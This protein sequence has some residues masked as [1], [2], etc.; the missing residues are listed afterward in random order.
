M[1][2]D[3]HGTYKAAI[4]W[5]LMYF[6][7]LDLSFFYSSAF[8]WLVLYIDSFFGA[9]ILIAL[10]FTNAIKLTPKKWSGLYRFGWWLSALGL[11]AQATRSYWFIQLGY[12]PQDNVLPFW[13]LKDLGLSVIILTILLTWFDIKRH[14]NTPN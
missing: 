3:M 1:S 11:I 8:D 12:Y 7:S 2:V 9:G 14:R 13:V 4:A 5:G 6:N 10:A